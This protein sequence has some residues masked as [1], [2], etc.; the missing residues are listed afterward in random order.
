MH[1]RQGLIKQPLNAGYHLVIAD[2]AGDLD[3]R[4]C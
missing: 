3:Y 2:V 1:K 4:W